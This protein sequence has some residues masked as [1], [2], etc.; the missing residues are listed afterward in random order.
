MIR[1]VAS[2]TGNLA[3]L[4]LLDDLLLLDLLNGHRGLFFDQPI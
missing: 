2:F 1:F 4:L 3:Q